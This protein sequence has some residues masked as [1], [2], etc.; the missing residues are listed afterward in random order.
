MLGH[1]RRCD[2]NERA[3]PSVLGRLGDRADTWTVARVRVSVW[4]ARC[5]QR[6]DA[7]QM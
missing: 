3:G 2:P 6:V 7:T 1:L 4:V 5:A